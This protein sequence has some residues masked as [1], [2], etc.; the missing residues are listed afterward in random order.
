MTESMIFRIE[1]T[2]LLVT[3]RWLLIV[4]VLLAAFVIDAAWSRWAGKPMREANALP[5]QEPQQQ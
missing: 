3:Y 1:V 2:D 4:V 5:T